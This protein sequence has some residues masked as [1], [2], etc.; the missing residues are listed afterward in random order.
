MITGIGG[1]LG[2]VIEATSLDE[3]LGDLFSAGGAGTSVVVSLLFAWVIAALLHFAI[4]SVSVA[5]IAAAGI[6][7]PIAG[8]LAVDPVVLGL[9]IGSGA[10][11]AVQVNS[12]FF[13][14]FQSMLGLTTQGAL[15]TLTISTVLASVFSLPLVIV[16]GLFT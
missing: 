13:W 15:K 2:A 14:M 16:V 3:T 6:L 9:A 1:S 10:L 7:A 12:N 11:F 4:G 5:G 8:S